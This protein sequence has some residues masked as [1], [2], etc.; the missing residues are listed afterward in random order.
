VDLETGFKFAE[1][2][3][4]ALM[5]AIQEALLAFANASEWTARMRRGMAKDFSWNASAAA[6][7]RLY[8]SLSLL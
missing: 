5:G 8:Q 4:E 1:Y 3:P 2:T 6:Y 7:Q